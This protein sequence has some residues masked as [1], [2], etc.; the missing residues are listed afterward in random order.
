MLRLSTPPRIAPSV[1]TEANRKPSL[2]PCSAA[3]H[4]EIERHNAARVKQSAEAFKLLPIPLTNLMGR[5]WITQG[6]LISLR[7]FLFLSFFFPHLFSSLL[8]F[9]VLHFSKHTQVSKQRIALF[10]LERHLI[11]SCVVLQQVSRLLLSSLYHTS[12]LQ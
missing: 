3:Q 1:Y 12:F 6:L 11:I 9:Y 8:F 10:P 7:S 2:Y 5:L 4:N